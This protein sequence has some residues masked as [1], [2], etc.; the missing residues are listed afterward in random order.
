MSNSKYD[1]VW[2]DLD[3]DMLQSYNRDVAKITGVTTVH[4]SLFGIISTRKGSRAFYP[5]FGCDLTDMLFE[6]WN[7]A[8]RQK[9]ESNIITSIQLFEPRVNPNT[10]SVTSSLE[11]ENSISITV[12][13]QLVDLP[14]DQQ[15]PDLQIDVTPG[16]TSGQYKMR[17]RDYQ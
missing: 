16:S 17:L 4:Y 7:P 13:F 12:A 10:I 14:Y 6:N 15:V 3:P 8:V 9:I 2:S 11:D 1:K 5:E